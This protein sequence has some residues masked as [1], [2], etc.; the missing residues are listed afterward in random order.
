MSSSPPPP[1]PP[2]PAAAP[3]KSEVSAGTSLLGL[4]PPL[5]LPP[6]EPSREPRNWTELA[7]ISTLCRLPPSLSSHSRQSSR[8]ST[9]TCLL[10]TSDAADDL[11]C[12]DL[13]G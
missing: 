3:S 7:M 2:P 12:V 6:P 13:G 1:P 9:A 4:K 5:P 8:P 11:L 10:Y